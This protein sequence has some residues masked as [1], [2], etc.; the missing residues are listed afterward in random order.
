MI[1]K[2]LHNPTHVRRLSM[3]SEIFGSQERPEEPGG[4]PPG[5]LCASL[6]RPHDGVAL[7]LGL[8]LLLS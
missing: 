8:G 5:D 6:L 7:Q 2:L 3:C 1:Y 4:D